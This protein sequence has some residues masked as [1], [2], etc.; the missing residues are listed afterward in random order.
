VAGL[1]AGMGEPKQLHL[2][3][4]DNRGQG[5][6]VAC[7][8]QGFEAQRPEWLVAERD[9]PSW[10]SLGNFIGERGVRSLGIRVIVRRGLQVAGGRMPLST[11]GT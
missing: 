5:S 8:G 4:R 7:P 1:L 6:A 10:G 2:V 9:D 11:S 3:A